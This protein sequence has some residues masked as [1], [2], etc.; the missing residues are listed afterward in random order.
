MGA[1]RPERA[2]AKLAFHFEQD[3]AQA[4]GGPLFAR[5]RLAARPRRG[6]ARWRGR[7]LGLAGH[8]LGWPAGP[9]RGQRPVSWRASGLRIS[10][11][12]GGLRVARSSGGVT[13][14]VAWGAAFRHFGPWRGRH[15]G[16]CATARGRRF[17]PSPPQ[18]RG[19]G[20]RYV[21]TQL[22]RWHAGCSP[23][24]RTAIR[25][26]VSPAARWSGLGGKEL[27]RA[28]ARHALGEPTQCE[29]FFASARA[30]SRSSSS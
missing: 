9:G 12:L 13:F 21:G 10:A 24:G 4:C 11:L 20:C 2:W 14:C 6:A 29:S 8:G 1:R 22:P 28:S 15:R 5:L 16:R 23:R 17:R 25:A 26:V 3:N 7:W 30:A 19:C 27:P 18:L